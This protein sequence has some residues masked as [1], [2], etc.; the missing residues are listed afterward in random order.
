MNE[1]AYGVVDQ[2]VCDND[3]ACQIEEVTLKGFTVIPNVI[4]GHELATWRQKIDHIYTVQEEQFG[5]DALMA[6]SEL[7]VC[8]APLLYD[9]DF[10]K[11][12]TAPTTQSVVRAFLGD[13]F[14]LNLQNAIINR[15]ATVHHQSAWHRDLP[16]QNLVT[17]H[18]LGINVL[19]A[20]DEFSEET[21]GTTLLPFSH[22]SETLPSSEY[23]ARNRVAVC[24]PAGSAVV[25]D[26]MLF[27]KA[28]SNRSNIVRRAVNQLFT[29]PIIK[30][31]YDFA[32]ALAQH[33]SSFD[34][35]V[36][37]LLGFTSRVAVDDKSWREAR[38]SRLRGGV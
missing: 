19:L 21:G 38:T 8:R 28:G 13:W 26:V 25:F 5:R 11:L 1:R 9:R 27:H 24:A 20:I 6:I 4:P 2:T 35:D 31:Q 3:L 34:M 12:A 22:K 37:R 18:P 17:S 16:Y 29:R 23:I 36:E 7:D 33:R 32:V 14:I 15:P 30:Q 10:L